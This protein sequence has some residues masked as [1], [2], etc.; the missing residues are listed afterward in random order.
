MTTEDFFGSQ[1]DDQSQKG[2]KF[3]QQEVEDPFFSVTQSSMG[4]NVDA[5]GGGGID[6]TWPEDDGWPE[7]PSDTG[8]ECIKSSPLF[9][10]ST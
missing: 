9:Y 3:D 8:W 4:E 5:G 6:N 2:R 10:C 7:W 1:A